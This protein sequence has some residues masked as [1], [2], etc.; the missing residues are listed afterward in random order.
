[1]EKI[2]ED[3]DIPPGEG[4]WAD[5]TTKDIV[6]VVTLLNE[7]G[8]WSKDGK[9]KFKLPE[10]M[11]PFD[12]YSNGKWNAVIDGEVSVNDAAT[13]IYSFSKVP[14]SPKMGYNN[15]CLPFVILMLVSGAGA[16]VLLLVFKKKRQVK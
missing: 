3:E 16:V 15:E 6:I 2:S 9:G 12:G 14:S 5:G 11:I 7:D 10:G 13:Y 8:K 4:K 1:M